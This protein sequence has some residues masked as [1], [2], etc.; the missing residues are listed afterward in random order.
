VIVL[1]EP[2][3]VT[4]PRR[5]ASFLDGGFT[6]MRIRSSRGDISVANVWF[7]T[8]LEILAVVLP[9]H[10][11]RLATSVELRRK[12]HNELIDDDGTGHLGVSS[13]RISTEIEMQLGETLAIGRVPNQRAE[14]RATAGADAEHTSPDRLRETVGRASEGP[15]F[16]V[17]VTP[18]LL[19]TPNAQRAVQPVPH[20]ENDEDPP[21]T[22]VPAEFTPADHD[23]LGP[24]M[25]V[26]R[27]R[28]L[29][30]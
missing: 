5:P 10:R 4:T 25:P 20:S 28:P 16:I 8:Q 3:L 15:E 29:R 2:N 6:P 19:S 22:I 21:G 12:L 23:A 14:R 7:G 11:V 13:R 1:A 9:H 17:L 24:P 30:D 26:L 18:E 27:R